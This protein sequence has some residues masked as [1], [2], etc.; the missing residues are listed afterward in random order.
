VYVREFRQNFRRAGSTTTRKD[1]VWRYSYRPRIESSFEALSVDEVTR[2]PLV[3]VR[4]RVTI[5]VR[6]GGI[7][8][9]VD[10][11]R[12]VAGKTVELQRRVRGRWLTIE[13]A[14]VARPAARF[15]VKL[16]AGGSKLRVFISQKQ[17]GPGY[18][19]GFSRTLVVR[20]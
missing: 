2:S 3:R 10:A 7:I 12:R 13:R 19:D 6:A 17:V 14:R 4:P 8:A 5:A 16:P 9:R 20:R 11:G 18:L 1:G 15:R